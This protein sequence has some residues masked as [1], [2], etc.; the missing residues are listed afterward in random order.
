M[1]SIGGSSLPHFGPGPRPGKETEVAQKPVTGTPLEKPVKSKGVSRPEQTM[2]QLTGK[3]GEAQ[4]LKKMALRKA[5]RRRRRRK[6][7]KQKGAGA[8][9]TTP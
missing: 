6:K 1:A 9:G 2:A 4:K 7:R 3:L 5:K 8:D